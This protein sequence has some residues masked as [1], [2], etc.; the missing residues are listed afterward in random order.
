VKETSHGVGHSQEEGQCVARERGMLFRYKNFHRV[1]MRP[2][3]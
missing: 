3:Q 1:D 2:K